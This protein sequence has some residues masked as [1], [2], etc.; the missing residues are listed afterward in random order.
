MV[1]AGG[2]RQAPWEQGFDVEHRM[3]K[4][5]GDC[6]FFGVT[7]TTCIP[8]VLLHTAPLRVYLCGLAFEGGVSR[9]LSPAVA[10]KTLLTGDSL[11]RPEIASL[12]S[13]G[14]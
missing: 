14:Y 13:S 11:K 10:S 12:F 2:A 1:D 9:L 3:K 7:E 5:G 8:S 4:S 6:R